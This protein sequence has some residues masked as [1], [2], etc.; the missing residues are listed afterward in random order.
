MKKIKNLL[1]TYPWV[2]S[3][4]NLI[5]LIFS[6][7]FIFFSLII[8]C[9]LNQLSS[10][11]SFRIN[12]LFILVWLSLSYSY[13]R[14][15]DLIKFIS[16][17]QRKSLLIFLFKT[18]L[19]GFTIFSFLSFLTTLNDDGT[20]K[21][22]LS[23]ILSFGLISTFFQLIVCKFLLFKNSNDWYL[24]GS[25]D[26]L[27]ILNKDF[28]FRKRKCNI[29][30]INFEQLKKSFAD[31]KLFNG[32]IICNEELNNFN[33]FIKLNSQMNNR[34]K[35]ISFYD[36]CHLYL[37]TVPTELYKRKNL[38]ENFSNNYKD[39]EFFIKRIGDLIF[40]L[41]LLIISSPVILISIIIIY[42]QD[43][44]SV[45]Y[46]QY[47]TGLNGKSFKI[48]KLRSMKINAEKNSP[49]WSTFS[50]NRITRFGKIIRLTRI[51]ELPQ[52]LSIIKGDMS[53]IGPRPERMEID[54]EL[55]KVIPNYNDRYLIKPGLS[56][57]A[58]VNY[59]YGASV[60]DS[61]IKMSFDLYYLKNVSI[62]LDLLI[63]FKT[64]R[65]VLN[66]RGSRPSKYFN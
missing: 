23:F 41:I 6:E 49:Q 14:Y 48:T 9:D 60:E 1:K 4:L 19:F 33:Q 43:R 17:Y 65:L 40:S 28:Y 37:E 50:D 59:P 3:R 29:K 51:D 13:E 24:L 53:L 36:W 11:K 35:F 2:L 21:S 30:L 15:Y 45:F 66:A 55:K 42:L 63:F 16:K 47:R 44:G 31:N 20:N 27:D 46:S 64:I 22:F 62:A 25:K 5:S 26:Y 54:D 38:D 61:R 39:L 58:Q 10:D 32:I 18:L 8:I 56:G 34:I 12:L 7:I 52:L 57:W